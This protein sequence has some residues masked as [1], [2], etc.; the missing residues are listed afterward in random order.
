MALEHRRPETYRWCLQ[1]RMGFSPTE[2]G[3][4]EILY[5][6]LQKPIAA[7]SERHDLEERLQVLSAA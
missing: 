7:A 2:H 3:A 5:N 1:Q 4:G 6:L